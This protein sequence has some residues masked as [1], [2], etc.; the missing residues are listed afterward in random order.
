[1]WASGFMLAITGLPRRAL[2]LSQAFSKC[3]HVFG[4][5][6]TRFHIF[7]NDL[8]D[9]RLWIPRSFRMPLSLAELVR[10]LYQHSSD[11]RF[12]S[13]CIFPPELVI[14]HT[15]GLLLFQSK[16]ELKEE[17]TTIYKVGG[18]FC[19]VLKFHVLLAHCLM[20]TPIK[21]DCY[22]PFLCF[23]ARE[24]SLKILNDMFDLFANLIS[25]RTKLKGC[26]QYNHVNICLCTHFTLF[27]NIIKTNIIARYKHIE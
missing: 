16:L 4:G 3:S 14:Q 15:Y 17:Y 27:K 26:T 10:W 21:D 25:G 24:S 1:M 7:T 13:Q 11:P 20:K 23:G 5:H 6:E 22:C 2:F 19:D 12:D 8:F 9:T 18:S